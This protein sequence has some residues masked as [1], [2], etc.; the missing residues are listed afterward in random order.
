MDEL[1]AGGDGSH[2]E[3]LHEEDGSSEAEAE[4]G[5]GRGEGD[6]R[7][8]EARLRRLEPSVTVTAGPLGSSLI[9]LGTPHP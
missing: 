9:A 4:R 6:V 2:D 7:E 1:C 5:R 3:L 8:R